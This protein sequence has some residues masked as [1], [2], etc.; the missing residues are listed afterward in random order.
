MPLGPAGISKGDEANGASE[1]GTA[2]GAH[3]GLLPQHAQVSV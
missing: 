2:G 1:G 3:G